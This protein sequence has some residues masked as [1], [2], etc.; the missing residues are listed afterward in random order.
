LLVA[1]FFTCGFQLAFVTA[2][3]QSYLLLKGMPAYVGG[4]TMAV[5]GLFNIV[6]SLSAGWLSGRMPMRYLLSII[7]FG[8]A[9]AVLIFVLLPPSPTAAL[10]Y[11]AITGLLWL[12]TVPPTNGLVLVMFGTRWLAMLSGV[13]FVSHQIGGALGVWLGGIIVSSYGSYDP[14]WWLSVL[15]GVLS[16]LINLPIVEKPV[17]RLAAQAA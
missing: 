13:A 16:A 7:Y 17:S 5:I 11:G 14:V 1:G 9:L 12:S 8:R 10:V 15:F 4:W 2:H 6:G 3:L